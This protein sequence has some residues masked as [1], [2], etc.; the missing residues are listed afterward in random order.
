MTKPGEQRRAVLDAIRNNKLPVKEASTLVG[1]CSDRTVR[2]WKLQERLTGSFAPQRKRIR[3]AGV[4]PWHIQDTLMIIVS[5]RP[6]M[7]HD[8]LAGLLLFV[9]GFA[10]TERQIRQVMDREHFKFRLIHEFRPMLQDVARI[11][12]W[13]EHIIYPGGP[14]T[15]R[16]VVCIDECSRQK[17]DAKRLRAFQQRGHRVVVPDPFRG[18]H[19]IPRENQVSIIVA[20]SIEGDEDPFLIFNTLLH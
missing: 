18:E 7:H 9:T 12:F 6:Q 10:Y 8:E 3:I 19:A 17:A 13:R 20:L 15:A 14:I 1:Q 5:L 11:R 16:H 4:M 2:R